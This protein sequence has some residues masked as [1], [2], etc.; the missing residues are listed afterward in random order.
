M[1]LLKSKKFQTGALSLIGVVVAHYIGNAA[2]AEQIAMLG[3]VVVAGIAAADF[4]K[5]SKKTQ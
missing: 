3:S 4:G 5:E 2:L 1:N